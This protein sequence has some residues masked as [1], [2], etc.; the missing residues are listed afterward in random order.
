MLRLLSLLTF[1]AF[2]GLATHTSAATAVTNGSGALTGVKGYDYLGESYDLALA[3]GT[4][5]EV[6][7][8]CGFDDVLS[9]FSGENNGFFLT[10]FVSN[11]ID[12]SVFDDPSLIFGCLA[13]GC[14]V[15]MPSRIIP[16]KSPVMTGAR[17][18]ANPG[19][20]W[21]SVNSLSTDPDG[22]RL[23]LQVS[24]ASA[25]S[26]EVPLPASLPLLAGGLGLI[27]ALRRRRRA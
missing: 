4:C 11:F 7:G 21:D 15:Y 3:T 14:T 20:G 24:L 8:S 9:P 25:T 19:V 5:V 6:F 22:S 16:D 1:L 27:A 10:D 13:S 26:A 2:S 12:R 23:Y 17:W 18:N